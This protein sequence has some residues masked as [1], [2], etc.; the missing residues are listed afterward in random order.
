[1]P[2]STDLTSLIKNWQLIPPLN[3]DFYGIFAQMKRILEYIILTAT[4][5]TFTTCKNDLEIL[6]PY[7]EIPNIYAVLNPKDKIQMIRINKVFLGEGN[8]FDMAKIADSINYKPGELRV[9]LEHYVNGIKSVVAGSLGG[10]EVLFHDSVITTKPGAFNTTQRIYVTSERLFNSGTYKLIVKNNNSNTEYF[11]KSNLV[12]SISG[13]SNAPFNTPYYPLTQSEKVQYDPQDTQWDN[14]VYLNYLASG[15]YSFKIRAISDAKIYQPRMRFHFQDSLLTGGYGAKNY[16][17]F[18]VNTFD[19][20][21]NIKPGDLITFNVRGSSLYPSL[22]T[23][24]ESRTLSSGSNIYGRKILYIEMICI[25][26]TQDYADYL[27][28]ATPSQS[29]AQDKPL[30][31]NFENGAFGLLAFRSRCSVKKEISTSMVSEI[32]SNV[33]TCNP[34]FKFMNSNKQVPCP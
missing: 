11:A 10:S 12:D 24:L 21:S 6:A 1:M 17:D 34:K 15:N 7:K 31:S 2:S 8:A 30:F 16:M 14:V 3:A 5:L 29:V 27:Q 33:N 20:P 28:Y 19:A 13:A 9:S 25:T 23:D 26:T 4:L 32:A 22:K 18:V